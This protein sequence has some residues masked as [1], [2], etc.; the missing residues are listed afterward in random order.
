[1]LQDITTASP[2]V[3]AV[4]SES[5]I[6]PFDDYYS[7]PEGLFIPERSRGYASTVRGSYSSQQFFGNVQSDEFDGRFLQLTPEKSETF[8]IDIAQKRLSL[9]SPQLFK[10]KSSSSVDEVQKGHL[11]F[12]NEL[13]A[14]SRG[15]LVTALNKLIAQH[16]E[17]E[18]EVRRSLGSPDLSLFEDRLAF[19]HRII[20]RGLP[21]RRWDTGRG[22]YSFRKVKVPLTLFKKTCTHQIRTLIDCHLWEAA[23][24]YVA[25]SWKYVSKL[26]D[27][28]EAHHNRI[29]RA[30][31]A[32][33][34][35]SCSTAIRHGNF[36]HQQ[37][38]EMREKLQF[39]QVK[40][41]L[42]SPSLKLIEQQL[43]DSS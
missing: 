16:P 1:M 3:Q 43:Q 31:F 39:C 36:R 9:S 20:Y 4:Y 17:L 34:A 22:S 21:S 42:I 33:L 32:L 40:N 41:C 30:C 24:S 15:Q 10:V 5:N 2:H 14:F 29:K 7:P 23:V 28:E 25:M 12:A 13:E 26:P 27:W 37:L 6:L 35:S 19:V 8:P 18:S 11:S 38:L